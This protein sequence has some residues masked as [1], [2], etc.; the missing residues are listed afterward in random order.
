MQCNA[1]LVQLLEESNADSYTT[2]M[3][4][5]AFQICDVMGLPGGPS[6]ASALAALECQTTQCLC[7]CPLCLLHCPLVLAWLRKPF[8]AECFSAA[9]WLFQV[10]FAAQKLQHTGCWLRRYTG[11]SSSTRRWTTSVRRPI[12]HPLLGE[13]IRH[14]RH[15]QRKRK[16]HV[17]YVGVVPSCAPRCRCAGAFP[18]TEERRGASGER[19]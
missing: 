3:I 7:V 18:R 19:P 8:V 12:Q 16:H 13:A 1:D 9:G 11:L 2:N 4:D 6:T 5:P 10:P 15:A 17:R 14:V